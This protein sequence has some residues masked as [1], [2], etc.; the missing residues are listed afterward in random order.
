MDIQFFMEGQGKDNI[1]YM[2]KRFKW[3]C[4]LGLTDISYHEVDVQSI[5]L[6]HLVRLR[7]SLNFINKMSYQF[8]FKDKHVA[9][10]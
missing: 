5:I 2:E 1:Q 9:V 4:N 8:V 7:K 10:Q 6:L 3:R